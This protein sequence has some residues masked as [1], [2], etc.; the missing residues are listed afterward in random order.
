MRQWSMRA[1]REY[2]YDVDVLDDMFLSR[3]WDDDVEWKDCDGECGE[4][5]VW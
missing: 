4:R 1:S 2:D 5:E 3:S